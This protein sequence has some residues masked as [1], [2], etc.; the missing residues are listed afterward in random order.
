MYIN[1][2]FLQTSLLS[3]GYKWC[4]TLNSRDYLRK[5]YSMQGVN[6]NHKNRND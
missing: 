3:A 4:K 1:L 5:F 2:E 6:Q